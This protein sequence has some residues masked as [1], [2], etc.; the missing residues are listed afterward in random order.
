MQWHR[1][2]PSGVRSSAQEF[3]ASI[4]GR[5]GKLSLQEYTA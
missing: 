5:N 2:V 1:T 4:S 3:A